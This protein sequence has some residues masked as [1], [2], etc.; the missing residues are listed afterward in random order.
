MSPVR[1]DRG[2]DPA[3]RQIEL[4]LSGV[5]E[6]MYKRDFAA[7]AAVLLL[8][9][10]SCSTTGEKEN[11]K[12]LDLQEISAAEENAVKKIAADFAGGFI[13]SMETGNF[14]YWRQV[15]PPAN[16]AK[17]NQQ[18]FDEMRQQLIRTFGKFSS[19]SFLGRLVTGKIHNFL[20]ILTFIREK[21]GKSEKFEVV[22][23]VRV[24]C[25]KDKA[26]AVN[27]FG[28]KLF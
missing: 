12:I 27:G 25:E 18:K 2:I 24:H 1:R 19:A 23:F 15:I 17:I 6:M 9:A 5:P 10:P 4:F 14:E 22:Y 3:R 7:L 20:W 16:A 21:D 26:P 11:R 28:V 8:F 13:K